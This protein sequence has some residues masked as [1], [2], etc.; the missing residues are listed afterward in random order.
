MDLAEE[1]NWQMFQGQTKTNRIAEVS[2][3]MKDQMV[4]SLEV[5]SRRTFNNSPFDVQFGLRN[6]LKIQQDVFS[7]FRIEMQTYMSI[8]VSEEG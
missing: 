1:E 8:K 3:T 6:R 2:W 4:C 7:I 5:T